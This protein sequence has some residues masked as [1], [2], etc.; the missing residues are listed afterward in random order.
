VKARNLDNNAKAKLA[1]TDREIKR[2]RYRLI[3]DIEKRLMVPDCKEV[4]E[5]EALYIYT[6][7]QFSRELQRLMNTDEARTLRFQMLTLARLAKDCLNR[8]N[9][10]WSEFADVRLRSILLQFDD[11]SNKQ[12][13]MV[14]PAAGD[15]PD[16]DAKEA[17]KALIRDRQVDEEVAILRE[18]KE[19]AFGK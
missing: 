4:D 8:L 3:T 15:D 17:E 2:R 11:L 16:Y 19:A 18:L 7:N 13:N 10:E 12:T 1:T 9:C 6:R 5:A 14:R